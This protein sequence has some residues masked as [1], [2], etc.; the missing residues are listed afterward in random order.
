MGFSRQ[1]YWSGLLFPSPEDLPNTRIEPWF[2]A[3][4]AD[5]LLFE[6]KLHL[7]TYVPLLCLGRPSGP[8]KPI[9]A[10]SVTWVAESGLAGKL[11]VPSS[12]LSGY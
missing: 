10:V 1:E 5:S 11:S 2:P 12:D 9:R 8:M 4:R 6:L 7:L 3:L